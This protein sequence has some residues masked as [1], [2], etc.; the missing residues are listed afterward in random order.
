MLLSTFSRTQRQAFALPIAAMPIVLQW[1]MF[2][3]PLRY[4][5]VVLRPEFLKGVGISVLWPQLAAMVPLAAAMLI[6]SVLR[7]RKSLD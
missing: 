4:F 7:F 3:N 2:L 6:A 1:L 5:L